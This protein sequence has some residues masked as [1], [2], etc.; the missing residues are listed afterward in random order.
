MKKSENDPLDSNQ[1]LRKFSWG[2]NKFGQVQ[3]AV[4]YKEN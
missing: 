4:S 2:S 1:R 3:L